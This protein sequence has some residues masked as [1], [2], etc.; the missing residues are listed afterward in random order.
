MS[1]Y[2][3]SLHLRQRPTKFCSLLIEA[4]DVMTHTTVDVNIVTS[5]STCVP[6]RVMN[7]CKVSLMLSLISFITPSDIIKLISVLTSSRVQ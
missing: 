4:L 2:M 5:S 3:M 6:G 1:H 7:T